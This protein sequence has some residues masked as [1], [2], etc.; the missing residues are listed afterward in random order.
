MIVSVFRHW[1]PSAFLIAFAACLSYVSVQQVYRQGAN[2]PQ[3]QMARD[4]ARLLTEGRTPSMVASSETPLDIS[5][6]LAP[7]IAVFDEQGKLVSSTGRLH[8]EEIS[9]PAGTFDYARGA[10][11][12]RFSWQPEPGVRQAVVMVRYEAKGEIGFVLAGRSLKESEAR[13]QQIGYNLFL[14]SVVT[15]ITSLALSFLL[16]LS[17]RRFPEFR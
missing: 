5:L 14:A 3:V 1:L 16:V 13:T 17:R 2:D 11:E 6:T 9:L 10:G 4:A 7:F 8:G 12:H 15:L